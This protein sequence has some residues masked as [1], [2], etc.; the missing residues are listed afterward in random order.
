MSIDLRSIITESGIEIV[1]FYDLLQY[2]HRM[3]D[4]YRDLS[5]FQGHVFRHNQRLAFLHIDTEYI[6]DRVRFTLY[7]LQKILRDLSISNY[8][9]MS[10]GHQSTIDDMIFI[11]D[12]L[13]DDP[14][15]ISQIS[16]EGHLRVNLP[17]KTKVRL[18]EDLIEKQYIFLSNHPRRHRNFMMSWLSY[19]GLT[20]K[21][22]INYSKKASGVSIDDHEDSRKDVAAS[23]LLTV[24]PWTRINEHWTVN[25]SELL[26]I[27]SNT[28]EPF[29]N[30][31][32]PENVNYNLSNAS[33]LQRAFCYVSNET[34]F[35]SLT[36]YTSEKSFKPFCSMRPMISYGSPGILAK[37]R[38]F[39]FKTW[40]NYW[41][42]DYD[43]IEDHTQR[44]QAVAGLIRNVS[45]I[46][47]KRCQEMLLDMQLILEHNQNLYV[48]SF[49]GNQTL[50]MREQFLTNLSR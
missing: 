12:L 10:I 30:F 47:I 28:V 8:F 6:V 36:C 18:R 43:V 29:K 45:S 1:G 48:D 17:P 49:V 16:F 31:Q 14:Y 26:H 24:S 23:G 37:L 19:H 39:G 35:N 22:L 46:P 40:N 20:D 5:K 15:P 42:E 11:R 33:L 4:L 9:C 38:S 7:N 32:E 3:D 50:S 27:F 25:D 21:G 13:T 2:D 44:F 41:S 34:M